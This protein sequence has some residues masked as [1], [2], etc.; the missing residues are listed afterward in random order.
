[1]IYG[2][3]WAINM[4]LWDA[5]QALAAAAHYR[6]LATS[7][8]PDGDNMRGI[9]KL[10]LSGDIA[11]S[12]SD[13]RIPTLLTMLHYFIGDLQTAEAL[14]ERARRTSQNRSGMFAVEVYRHLVY[15]DVDEARSLAVAALTEPRRYG[16]AMMTTS[17]SCDSRSMR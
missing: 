5:E 15:G 17:S 3:M 9:T 4:D 11:G 13:V 1:M 6:E 10:L 8:D 12:I 7:S 14:M 2:G 16:G